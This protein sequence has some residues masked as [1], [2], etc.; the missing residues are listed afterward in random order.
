[1]PTIAIPPLPTLNADLIVLGETVYTEHCAE[2]HGMNLEGE[3]DWEDLNED[4]SYRAPAHDAQGHTWQHSDARLL[5]IVKL[6]GSRVAP[7]VGMS[8]MPPYAT[9]LSDQEIIA[10]LTFIKSSW[11]EEIRQLQWDVTV[12]EGQ[13]DE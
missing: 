11:P 12:L 7:D 1:M 9:V 3:A 5:Q 6:G 13:P 2:C 4:G 10:V 8:K